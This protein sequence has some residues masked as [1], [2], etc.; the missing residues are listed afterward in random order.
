MVENPAPTW[1]RIRK[2]GT[3]RGGLGKNFVS[4]H[5]GTRQTL[6]IVECTSPSCNAD[7]V[8]RVHRVAFPAL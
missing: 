3:V 2:P 6:S 1:A 7:A 5:L 8:I 4:L